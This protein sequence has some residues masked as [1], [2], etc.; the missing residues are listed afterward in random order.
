MWWIDV[1]WRYSFCI[2]E[3]SVE[4]E[5]KVYCII[6]CSISGSAFVMLWWTYNICV[7][8]FITL[9]VVSKQEGMMPQVHFFSHVWR[10]AS[11]NMP[12]KLSIFHHSYSGIFPSKCDALFKL[13][14]LH[15]A[16]IS[17]YFRLRAEIREPLNLPFILVCEDLIWKQLSSPKSITLRLSTRKFAQNRR[18]INCVPS[19]GKQTKL[20][21]VRLKTV[22]SQY[23]PVKEF[24][25][26]TPHTNIT[27]LK[28]FKVGRNRITFL[29]AAQISCLVMITEQS[30]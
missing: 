7:R 1:Q 22:F 2:Q 16:D 20:K 8:Y 13:K 9:S 23:N 6:H 18:E 17:I 27:I 3:F 21:C 12:P 5:V 15:A 11:E 26:S 25:T 29:T 10:F 24:P 30:T 19:E 14:S 4:T 28:M